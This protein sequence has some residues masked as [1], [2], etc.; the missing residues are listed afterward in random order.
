MDSGLTLFRPFRTDPFPS[1]FPSFGEPWNVLINGCSRVQAMLLHEKRDQR[2]RHRL[3]DGRDPETCLFANRD[4]QLPAGKAIGSLEDHTIAPLHENHA[5]EEI[6]PRLWLD[7][8]LDLA[9]HGIRSRDR[10]G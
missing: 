10:M 8:V 1:S 6:G 9:R 2:L 7:Q 4:T 5:P 3:R